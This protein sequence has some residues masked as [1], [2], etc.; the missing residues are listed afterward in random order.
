[1]PAAGAPTVYV[2][3]MTVATSLFPD[4]DDIVKRGDP[5]RLAKVSRGIA[6]LFVQGS[7]GFQPS[8][9]ELFDQILTGLVPQTETAARAAIAR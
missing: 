8:H 9:I 3:S 7:A 4:L 5:R 1:M 6:E 2:W